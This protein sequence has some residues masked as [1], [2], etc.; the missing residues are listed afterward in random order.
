MAERREKRDRYFALSI[1][2]RTVQPNI[3]LKPA[4]DIDIY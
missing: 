3:P 4:I 2:E 1:E